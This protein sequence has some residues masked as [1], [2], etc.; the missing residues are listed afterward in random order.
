MGRTVRK[1]SN[2]SLTV[3]YKLSA[4][5]SLP[6]AHTVGMLLPW[7]PKLPPTTTNSGYD[8][9]AMGKGFPLFS[10][11]RMGAGGGLPCAVNRGENAVMQT[12]YVGGNFF[13]G[14]AADRGLTLSR[15]PSD[16]N[17]PAVV[18]GA[19]PSP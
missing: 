3:N 13:G 2:K 17:I 12:G 1:Q 4:K 11:L 10:H 8:G 19:G 6:N 16:A 9:R 7:L 15:K 14:D 18:S 5:I